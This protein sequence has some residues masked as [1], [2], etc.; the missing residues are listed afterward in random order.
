MAFNYS[1]EKLKFD[2]EWKQKASWYRKEGMSEG[3]IDEMYCFDLVQFN[4]DR[5][6]ES[7]RRPLET[8]CG[9]C[10]IQASEARILSHTGGSTK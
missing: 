6:Y 5:A 2:A 4:R 9:C 3:D 10:Y 1:K 7:R 8:A